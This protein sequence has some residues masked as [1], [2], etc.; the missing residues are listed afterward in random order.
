[1]QQPQV[2]GKSSLQFPEGV[3][4]PM[5]RD[6]HAWHMGNGCVCP[7]WHRKSEPGQV[8]AAVEAA[9]RAGYR[10][11]DCAYVYENEHEVGDR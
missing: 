10:H 2:Q 7:T 5:R 3:R 9:V 1:M 6:M 4:P 8:Q 11:I